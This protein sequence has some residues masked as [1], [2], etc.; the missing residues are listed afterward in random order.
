MRGERAVRRDRPA[1]DRALPVVGDAE[2]D[3]GR[4]RVAVDAREVGRGDETGDLGGDRR[5]RVAALLLPALGPERRTVGD[6]EVRRRLDVV[7][8]ERGVGEPELLGHQDRVGGLVE[9]RVERIGRGLAVD[10]AVARHRPV[11]QL[12]VLEEEERRGAR[13][14][15]VAVGDEARP[16]LVEIARED[17]AV[18]AEVRVRR[19]TGRD[20]LTPRRGEARDDRAGEGL[21]L[22]RLEHVGAHVVLVLE[23]V[24]LG[25][26]EARRASAS[27][28]R[29]ASCRS[30]AT[31][32][33]R[34]RASCRTAAPARPR[35]RRPPRPARRRSRARGR[36]C[37]RVRASPARSG[38][39]C[40]RSRR[41]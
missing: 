34:R 39:R 33:C 25:R 40:R 15:E 36:P 17:L 3:R 16:G 30:A 22:R 7:G 28:A 21:V 19:V 13:G 5:R 8:V 11:R 20:R 27:A 23:A 9:L 6:Q 35:R 26:R 14:G 38:R 24:S 31:P 29:S 18:G 2:P 10:E 37:R 32:A 1:L 4:G 12:L 41:R